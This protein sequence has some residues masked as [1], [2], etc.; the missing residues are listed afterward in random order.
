MDPHR[1]TG[2]KQGEVN[3]ITPRTSTMIGAVL[4]DCW[5]TLIQAPNLMRRGASVEHFY[6]SLTASGCDIDFEAFRGAYMAETR[7]QREEARA[8]LRELDY[9]RRI[10]STLTAVGFQHPQR[11]LLA[12][13]AWSDYLDEWPKQSKPYGG[14]PMLLSSM[15]GRYGLGLVTNF[16][17][18][19]T[20][21]R[22]F[23]KLGFDTIF[24][25]LVVSGEVG[26]RKPSRVIYGKAL[27]ELGANPEE[28]VMVGDTLDA[29]ILGAKDMGM[30][31]I[32]IDADGSQ[33]DNHHL[34]DS[35]VTSIGEVDGALR[36]L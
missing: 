12:E 18:G 28:T 17:D 36:R 5:G 33:S 35:V 31:A 20:A 21:R 7:R 34:P 3:T 6:R 2:S 19:P 1:A 25:S 27:S 11:R 4:F 9:V 15:K 23:E 26:F 29:D 30:K 14:T 13:R 16:P 10:D 32:F 22:A 24:D 8:D